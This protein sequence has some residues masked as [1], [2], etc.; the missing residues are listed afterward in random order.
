MAGYIVKRLVWGVFLLLAVV[1]ITYIVFF[2]IPTE[3]SRF[4]TRNELSASDIRTAVGVHGSVF[5]E[6][7][8]YVWH[9]AHGSL[10]RSYRGRV[11]V[12][13]V[14]VNAAPVTASLVIGGAVTWLLIAFPVG[15]LSAL[16]SR[17]VFDRFAM[18]DDV[19]AKAFRDA[20][21]AVRDFAAIDEIRQDDVG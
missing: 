4:V 21:H 12:S 7:G 13:S 10:G 17:S 16:R 11:E 1:A 3:R 9:L 20:Q 14:I 2:V 8:Q 19:A 18:H 15:V 6:Y 5:Q